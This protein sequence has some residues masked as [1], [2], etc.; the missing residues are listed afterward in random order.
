MKNSIKI[1]AASIFAFGLVS[2]SVC[3]AQDSSSGCGLGWQVNQR[4]SLVSSAIRASTNAT[5]S[6]TIAMTF[7]T[8]G[9]AKHDI[10]LN[11]K[12]PIYFAE[13]NFHNLM[14]EMAAGHGEFLVAFAEVLGCDAGA[15][16]TFGQL[17]QA[18]YN[19]IYDATATPASMLLRTRAMIDANPALAMRCQSVALIALR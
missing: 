15:S 9:C 19:E 3:Q 6:N 7:G 18:H 14:V 17:T 13:A 4:T 12:Q 11:E 8:S 2:S 1:L 10:V 16:K 5:F